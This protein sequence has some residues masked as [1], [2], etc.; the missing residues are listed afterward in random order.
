VPAEFPILTA[1]TE[2]EIGQLLAKLTSGERP[3][4]KI[5]AGGNDFEFKDARYAMALRVLTFEDSE[6]E[7]VPKVQEPFP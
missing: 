5:P 7:Q 6:Q 4:L 2:L 1:D 3:V